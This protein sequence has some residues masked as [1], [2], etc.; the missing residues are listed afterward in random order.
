MENIIIGF[1]IG[2]CVGI[3]FH[4]AIIAWLDRVKDNTVAKL[5]AEIE[6]LKAKV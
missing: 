5:R 4:A 3:F 1:C 2:L 6:V